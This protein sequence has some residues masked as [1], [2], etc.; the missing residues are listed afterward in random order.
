MMELFKDRYKLGLLTATL[1]LIGILASAYQVYRLPHNLM[2]A[3]GYHPAFFSVYVVLSL[4]FL[5]GAFTVW[6]TLNYRNEVIVFRDKELNKQNAG[7]D[8]TESDLSTISL[9]AIKDSLSQTRTQ[10]EAV[11]AGLHTM[12]KLLDAGQ[13][14]VYLLKEHDGQRKLEL[15]NGYA[16]SIG[17]SKVITFE[18]GEGLVGQAAVTGKTLYVDDVPEGY[19]KI[20]SGLGSA[21]PR[22]LLIV[23]LKHQDIVTGVMEIASFTPL[24]DHQRKFVEES[25][26]LIAEKISSIN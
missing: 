19:V 24:N 16:L 13:G 4:T 20:I 3:G 15:T 2:L 14:A 21:S 23:A 6:S 7:K 18:I 1:F 17:E 9:D 12:C 22:Y 8:N 5:I 10:K 11:Q 26:Q 25:A